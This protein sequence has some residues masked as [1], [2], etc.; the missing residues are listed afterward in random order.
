LE[1]PLFSLRLD[2]WSA[3]YGASLAI[4]KEEGALEVDFAGDI[5]WRACS[6]SPTPLPEV[7]GVVD[8]VRRMELFLRWED[9]SQSYPGAIATLAVGCLS[10]RPGSPQSL[11]EALINLRV[12]PI[13]LLLGGPPPVQIEIRS[14]QLEPSSQELLPAMQEEMRQWEANLIKELT[15]HAW[16][17]CDGPLQA[18]HWQASQPAVGFI[19][20][21]HRQL[22]PEAENGLLRQLLPGQRTSLFKLSSSL[23]SRYSWYQRLDS[24]AKGE[25]AL[26]GL[27]RLEVPCQMRLQEAQRIADE[28]GQLLEQWR[29]P[30]HRDPRSPQNLIP[31]AVLENALRHRMGDPKLTQR[32]LRK[33]IMEGLAWLP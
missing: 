7:V 27:V 5:P 10:L 6:L 26:A 3:E 33:K 9:A 29:N 4:D 32:Q 2:P 31:I 16:V 25:S 23:G 14:K 24:G 21:Q 15:P 12:E 18:P 22:L 28:V 17:L 30:R 13:L 11:R 1:A 8:G 19:K 20:S